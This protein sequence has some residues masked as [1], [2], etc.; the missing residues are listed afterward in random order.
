MPLFILMWIG[1][2]LHVLERAVPDICVFCGLNTDTAT[3]KATEE[4]GKQIIPFSVS[5][6]LCASGKSH[7]QAG[8]ARADELGDFSSCNLMS[9]Q[10]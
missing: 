8:S 5:F 4:K 9:R 3:G 2:G 10:G 1:W 7:S 6:L